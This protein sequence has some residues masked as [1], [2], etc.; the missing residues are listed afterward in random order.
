MGFGRG[1]GDR[2][3]I[4]GVQTT[5]VSRQFS[6]LDKMLLGMPESNI[7]LISFISTDIFVLCQYKVDLV[8]RK[9]AVAVI[10]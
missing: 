2:T 7:Q 10:L 1:T 3:V 6:R 9:N 5:L 8:N 4:T